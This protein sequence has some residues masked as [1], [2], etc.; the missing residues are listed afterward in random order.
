[1]AWGGSPISTRDRGAPSLLTLIAGDG[2][3]VGAGL[4]VPILPAVRV[5]NAYGEGVAGFSVTFSIVA[6]GGAI[7]GGSTVTDSAGIATV[8]SWTLGAGLN[9]LFAVGSGLLGS[10]LVFTCTGTSINLDDSPL[11]FLL[12]RTWSRENRIYVP[13]H[14]ELIV[15]QPIVVP[16]NGAFYVSTFNTTQN[17]ISEGG[18][19]QH[20]DTT[21]TPMKISG[22]HAF[23]T[24][25]GSGG[26]NDSIAYL[27]NFGTDY[28]IEGTL[29]IDPGIGGFGGSHEIELWL[30][31]DDTGSQ[32][33]TTFGPTSTIGYEINIPSDGSFMSLARFKDPTSLQDFT[34]AIRPGGGVP[35]TGDRFKIRVDGHRIRCFYNG[36]VRIDYTDNG[37]RYIATGGPGMGA[38]IS[39]PALNT[40][41]GFD[42]IWVR[43]AAWAPNFIG[44][45]GTWNL[46]SDY[47]MNATSYPAVSD[48]GASFDSAG[49]TSRSEPVSGWAVNGNGG[50][51]MAKV[52]D[53]AQLH[54]PGNALEITYPGSGAGGGGNGALGIDLGGLGAVKRL[55][56]CTDVWHASDAELNS[57]SNKFMVVFCNA[58]AGGNYNFEYRFNSAYYSLIDGPG[59]PGPNAFGPTSG[60]ITALNT[61]VMVEWYLDAIANVSQCWVNGSLLWTYSRTIFTPWDSFLLSSTW[62]GGGTHTHSWKRRHG[63]LTLHYALT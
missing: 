55:Y 62:G 21:T 32:F 5:T 33:S 34:G 23:G 37:A 30:R 16:G 19:W 47:P 49:E 4:A 29:F 59:S 25:S 13:A 15:P 63:H 14:D 52:T 24:Q 51:G 12:R 27:L 10:P 1:M 2:Q 7:T 9:Q 3:S 42:T 41:F 48:S 17:P 53:T 60:A 54:S 61:W 22:G 18:N 46:L 31:V 43:D 20:S 57:I 56:A 39:N 45:P 50:S 36:T 26:T 44:L 38:F 11:D 6:G 35:Q 28:E 8:G 58:G 40:N